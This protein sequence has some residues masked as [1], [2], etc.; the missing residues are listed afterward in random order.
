VS[1]TIE[2]MSPKQQGMIARIVQ[3]EIAA[4]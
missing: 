1:S 4:A 3:R 2:R